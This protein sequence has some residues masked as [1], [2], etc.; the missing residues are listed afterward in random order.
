RSQAM[1]ILTTRGLSER[2]A[3]PDRIDQGAYSMFAISGGKSWIVVLSFVK[4]V[5]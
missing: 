4:L 3:V 2:H 5:F 1:D